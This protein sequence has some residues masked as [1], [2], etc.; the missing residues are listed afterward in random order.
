MRVVPFF[1]LAFTACSSRGATTGERTATVASVTASANASASVSS[2]SANVDTGAAPSASASASSGPTYPGSSAGCPSDMVKVDGD[3]CP[4]PSQICEKHA[5]DWDRSHETDKTVSERCPP[6]QIAVDDVPL[7]EARS[8]LLLHGPLRVPERRR[9][10]P[11]RAHAV[12]GREEEMC[13]EKG[14]RLCTVNEFD[15]A[16]EGLAFMLPYAYGFERDTTAKICNVDR[17][18]R[19]PDHSHQ[20][21]TYDKCMLDPACSAEMKRLDQRETIGE[22]MTCVSWAGV[23][24]L[25]GNV[26]EWVEIPKAKPPNRSGLKG[27][28]WGPVRSRCRPTVDFHKEDDYGYEQGF[29]CCADAKG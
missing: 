27:G 29:R 4:A 9:R 5:K 2:T 7:E 23:F 12:D 25:N 14:K 16:C 17:A 13:E 20:M 26:N 22:R 15:F 3:F 28:W 24:D 6:L 19:V 10:A 11:A 18:Y 8:P 21:K 1:A